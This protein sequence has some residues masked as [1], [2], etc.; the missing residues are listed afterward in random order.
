MK[1]AFIDV[2]VPQRKGS[3]GLLTSPEFELK[4]LEGASKGKKIFDTLWDNAYNVQQQLLWHEISQEVEVWEKKGNLDLLLARGRQLAVKFK[5]LKDDEKSYH[6]RALQIY[7]H[8]LEVSRRKSRQK[9]RRETLSLLTL[10]PDPFATGDSLQGE[11]SIEP[12]YNREG[13][14]SALGSCF[15]SI[16]EKSRTVETPIPRESLDDYKR[17]SGDERGRIMSI[18]I[19]EASQPG[20]LQWSKKKQRLANKNLLD[21]FGW[22]D[23]Q[24]DLMD[25]HE[26]EVK[27]Q[28][29]RRLTAETFE[30]DFEEPIE[31]KVD[32]QTYFAKNVKDIRSKYNVQVEGPFE[33]RR[34]A[35]RWKHYYGFLTSGGMLI[36]FGQEKN[37]PIDFKKAVDF[38]Q[39]SIT[40]LNDN[41]LRFNVHS[42]G[43][44]WLLKFNTPKEFSD[45]HKAI[46]KFS[47]C[48]AKKSS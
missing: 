18:E 34:M 32:N 1:T 35:Y 19:D 25:E 4:L 12:S 5:D 3:L 43:R 46:K 36:Y 28:C 7:C 24:I 8:F 42:A 14:R 41:K 27:S 48:H 22:D 26:D 33:K 2:Y 11:P 20:S 31:W 40:V 16:D 21:P 30:G 17:P 37:K 6:L 44:N 29:G 23:V 45:W 10:R 15:D 38:R 9:P 13:K 39:N 47:R